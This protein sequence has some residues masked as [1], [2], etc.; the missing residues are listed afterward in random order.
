[1]NSEFSPTR[2]IYG[3]IVGRY[4]GLNGIPKEWVDT[5]YNHLNTLGGVL[6]DVD[7]YSSQL[8]HSQSE[9]RRIEVRRDFDAE[10]FSVA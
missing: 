4:Y 2:G 6:T 5:F 1:L 8:P 3:Q 7:L 9:G 10:I